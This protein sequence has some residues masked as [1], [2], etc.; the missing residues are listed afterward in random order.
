VN[1]NTVA[2][3]DIADFFGG[4]TEYSFNDD[5]TISVSAY[6]SPGGGSYGAVVIESSYDASSHDFHVKF[7]I[8]SGRYIF[9][10]TYTR[11]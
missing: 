2:E 4:Y 5:G 7:S 11:K 6:D 1:G 9:D 3:N 10:L 8:L